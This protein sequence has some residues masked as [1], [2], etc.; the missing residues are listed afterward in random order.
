ML[1]QPFWLVP[2]MITGGEQ[3]KR[4]KARRL[5]MQC[6]NEK[7]A[8]N[9]RRLSEQTGGYAM[10]S[11]PG[12][13]GDDETAGADAAAAAPAG[14]TEDS[15]PP[16]GAAPKALLVR[17][18]TLRKSEAFPPLLIVPLCFLLGSIALISSTRHTRERYAMHE[19]I[20]AQ[21][22]D[23]P[24]TGPGSDAVAFADVRSVEDWWVWLEAL[25]PRVT[26]SRHYGNFSGT[27]M[28][29][30]VAVVTLAQTRPGCAVPAADLLGLRR[31]PRRLSYIHTTL[32]GREHARRPKP[33]Y[34]NWP[35]F[36][37]SGLCMNTSGYTVTAAPSNETLTSMQS[38]VFAN[39]TALRLA[40]ES[41]LEQLAVLYGHF[42]VTLARQLGPPPPGR[43]PGRGLSVEFAPNATLCAF[44]CDERPGCGSWTVE[45]GGA[46]EPLCTLFGLLRSDPPPWEPDGSGSGSDTPAVSRR[47]VSGQVDQISYGFGK[48][49][50]CPTA[51]ASPRF[52]SRQDWSAPIDS[53]L[54]GDLHLHSLSSHCDV[55]G[56]RSA[57][58]PGDSWKVCVNLGDRYRG[59]YPEVVPELRRLV[60]GPP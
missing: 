3:R 42:V 11:N 13:D 36:L 10:H 44:L 9:Q 12:A 14:S 22:V 33:L 25:V 24:L 20:T 52:S 60:S 29:S 53:G 57:I 19:G 59:F 41:A 34:P 18:V 27:T 40:A 21:F 49:W 31:Q 6:L 26:A 50:Q 35:P 54:L 2:G 28:G 8:L 48:N 55:A 16:P 58:T 38:V 23:A 4:E 30:D 37:A 39:R 47:C 46:T 51:A 1:L 45:E 15:A 56:K 7:T 32:G 43:Q 17:G 5:G